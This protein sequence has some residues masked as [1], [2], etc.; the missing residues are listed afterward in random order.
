MVLAGTNTYTGAT[1]LS[2]GTL[3]AG[4]SVGFNNTSPLVMTGSSILDLGGFNGA[5]TNLTT[6]AANT[7]TTTL[8]LMILVMK[9]RYR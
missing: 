7:I 5:F 2:E 1:N 4:S 3:K 6:T 9:L 8:A